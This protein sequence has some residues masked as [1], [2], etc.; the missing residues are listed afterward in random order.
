MKETLLLLKP[1]KKA[2]LVGAAFILLALIFPPVVEQS[3]IGGES[4]GFSMVF[5]MPFNAK[6]HIGFLAAELV[7]ISTAT[8]TAIYVLKDD[9]K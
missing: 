8:A 5:D 4:F 2:A 6:V 9:S 7:G 3:R 1:H